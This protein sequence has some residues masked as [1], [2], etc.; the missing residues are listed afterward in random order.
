[1]GAAARPTLLLHSCCGPCASVT[2]PAW[3]E[4]GHEVH[5]LFFNPNIEPK[6]EYD[7]RLAAM[8]TLADALALPLQVVTAEEAGDETRAA[9][10]VWQEAR[11]AAGPGDRE[12]R[13]RLCVVVRLFETAR[14]AALAG[15]PGF[16]TTLA[17]SPHQDHRQIR[18][19]GLMAAATFDVELLYDDQ[20][21]LFRRHYDE[22]R[23]LGL[24]RQSY[25]GCVL[26]K[27]EAWH[28]RQARRRQR[29]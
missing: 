25:C 19:A 5:A 11:D 10:E 7:R 26:S 20:R 12:G 23:R 4:Q 17:I 24:Y 14:R 6:A 13:C 9:L 27:W 8:V 18:E 2:V 29:G 1:M 3:R 28:E 16:A 22:S 21:S 15:V